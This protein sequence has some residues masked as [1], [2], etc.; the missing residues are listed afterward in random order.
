MDPAA[1][2]TIRA[3]AHV[4]A[5]NL[6]RV[7]ENAIRDQLRVLQHIRRVTHDAWYEHPALGQAPVAPYLPLVLVADVARLNRIGLRSD[8]YQQVDNVLQ[9]HVCAVWA[10]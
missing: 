10:V 9:L 7:V 4:L 8:L 6:I 5:T 3:G 1:Q 2:A